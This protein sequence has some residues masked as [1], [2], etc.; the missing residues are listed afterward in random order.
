MILKLLT[1]IH[2]PNR[3]H[4]PDS[5]E[6]RP[7]RLHTRLMHFNEVKCQVL[8]NRTL[9]NSRLPHNRGHGFRKIIPCRGVP[10]QPITSSHGQRRIFLL[11]GRLDQSR[12]P[13]LQDISTMVKQDQL[14]NPN[15]SCTYLILRAHRISKA[16]RYRHNPSCPFRTNT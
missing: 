6:K 14:T 9:T 16:Y 8:Y 3:V 12:N 13:G 10:T 5:T 1:F 4:F 2:N 11:P 15:R 7:S